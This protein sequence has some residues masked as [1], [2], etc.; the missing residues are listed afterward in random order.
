ME[1]N[2][3]VISVQKGEG[4]WSWTISA[5]DLSRHD[6]RMLQQSNRFFDSYEAALQDAQIVFVDLPKG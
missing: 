1:G 4:G 3:A 2:S 5:E 6:M